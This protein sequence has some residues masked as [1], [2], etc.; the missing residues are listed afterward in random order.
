[1]ADQEQSTAARGHRK[2]RVGYVESNKMDKTVVVS[3]TRRYMH[4]KYK[5]YVKE[6][7]RYKAHDENNDCNVGDRVLLEE[8]RPLSRHKRWRV[9]EILERAPEV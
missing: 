6:R 2:T 9:K 7:L 4:S 3:V 5:K 1:M 8:T